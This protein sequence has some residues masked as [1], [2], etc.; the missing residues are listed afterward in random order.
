MLPGHT[1]A[2]VLF[3]FVVFRG[4]CSLRYFPSSQPDYRVKLIIYAGF[5]S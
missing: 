1:I 3:S 5:F 4:R 2:Y